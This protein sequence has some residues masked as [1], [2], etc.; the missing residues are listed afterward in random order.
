[1]ISRW[2]A[3]T[4]LCVYTGK[5]EP[6]YEAGEQTLYVKQL[7]VHPLYL[8]A[9]PENDLAV[10]ELKDKMR[11]KNTVVPACLPERD[12]AERVLMSGEYMGVVT[13]WKDAPEF[14]GKLRLNHL[15]Y[16]NLQACMERHAGQVRGFLSLG[17]IY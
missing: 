1:M 3:L 16:S 6:Q 5:K 17:T 12:F 9:K 14:E 4:C 7:H 13:G 8:E 2:T 11:F 15:S 10:I